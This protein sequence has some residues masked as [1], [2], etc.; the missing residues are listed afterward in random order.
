MSAV[1][2]PNCGN[3]VTEQDGRCSRCG[4]AVDT[5]AGASEAASAA[6]QRGKAFK[7]VRAVGVVLFFASVAS[8]STILSGSTKG[9]H[10]VVGMY[11]AFFG[12]LFGILLTFCARA[13]TS[14]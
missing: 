3:S 7:I 13:F 2:C 5:G 4:K 1:T 10:H 11:G 9:M 12:M 6:P 14:R 8:C